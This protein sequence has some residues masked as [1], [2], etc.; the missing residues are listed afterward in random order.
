MQTECT[1]Q[2]GKKCGG[3]ETSFRQATSPCPIVR[4]S[5]PGPTRNF[6]P[7]TLILIDVPC[8]YKCMYGISNLVPGLRE[9]S[10]S[11]SVLG[12]NH[13][14]LL[15]GGPGGR[16]YWFLFIKNEKKL[17]GIE[18]DIPRRYTKEEEKAVAEQYWNDPIEGDLKFG[19]LYKS[20]ISAIL[21]PL[22][23]YV[24]KK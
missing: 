9:K 19:D 2:S 6:K 22:P 3:W 20:N 12:Q 18:K 8:D 15:F 4:V 17:H 10:S 14:H 16:I 5:M 24:C 7:S 21:T 23:E 11:I 13:S 1:A